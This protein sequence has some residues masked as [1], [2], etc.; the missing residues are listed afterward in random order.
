[1][2]SLHFIFLAI[3]QGLT[4]FL[5]ISSSAHLILISEFLGQ[6]DQGLAFDIG[7]HF[8][9]LMAVLIY[10]KTEIKVMIFN[11]MTTN[12]VHKEN[13]L[14]FNLF[15]ATIPIL[16]VGYF[17]RNSVEIF[18]RD[19]KIIAYATIGFGLLLYFAQK[20][21][22]QKEGLDF[23]TIKKA[24]IIGLAQC[25][26]L[27]PG[28]SRSGVTI[29]AGLFLGLNAT[30]ASRFSFLLAIPTIGLIAIVELINL[31]F[32]DLS[33]DLLHLT[34]SFFLSLIVA[35]FSIDLFLKLIDKIGFTPF[36]I[37]RVFLGFYLL[38]FWL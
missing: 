8:G 34:Y 38:F 35:Y 33:Q 15:I 23:L 30:A 28:T 10:F 37:Y 13:K 24:L 32:L 1:M 36:V 25:F 3:V 11:L 5:P 9:T 31:T 4:E 21:N 6:E 18:F 27:I 7:V 20:I 22:Y 17:F 2:E 12:F 19:P 29:T 14:F 16:I 26:A